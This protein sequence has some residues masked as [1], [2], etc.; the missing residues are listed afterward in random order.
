[1]YIQRHKH[2]YKQMQ[3][4]HIIQGIYT[5]HCS[6]CTHANSYMMQQS[7]PVYTCARRAA[8]TNIDDFTDSPAMKII[9]VRVS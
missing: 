9:G 1:M 7:D 2:V 8:N 6:D 5:V 4:M 3:K